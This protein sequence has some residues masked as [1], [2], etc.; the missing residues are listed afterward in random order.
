[1]EI[2]LGLVA[3][4]AW[5]VGD[6]LA[7][8]TGRRL[9]PFRAMLGTNLVGGLALTAWLLPAG[10]LDPARLVSAAGVTAAAGTA[11]MLGAGLLFYRAL[12]VG[13]LALVAPIGASFAA[14]PVALALLTGD[15]PAPVQL[16]GIAVTFAGVVLAATV[17]GPGLSQL[18]APWRAPGVVEAV[19]AAV[20]SGLGF[21]VLSRS[22]PDLGGPVM[23]WLARL[24]IIAYLL[25]LAAPLRQPVAIPAGAHWWWLAP[26]GL[27]DTLATGAYTVGLAGPAP[28]VVAILGSLFSAVT[29]LLAYVVLRERLARWQWAGV[30]VILV[31]VA[32]VSWRS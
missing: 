30:A 5:G 7:R 20:L 19:G 14:V 3:A 12:I 16:A 10:D 11:V 4:L 8:E 27:L 6:F 21:W 9:G 13:H 25:L 29:V 24:T 1:V 26:V 22:T 31:G 17:P 2:T 28:S 15:R 23:L 32:L 18:R